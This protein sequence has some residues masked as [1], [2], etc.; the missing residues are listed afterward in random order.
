MNCKYE[1]TQ[2][3]FSSDIET[4]LKSYLLINGI[5]SLCIYS[6]VLFESIFISRS[7]EKK[8]QSK[9][10]LY[11][12]FSEIILSINYIIEGYTNNA[13]NCPNHICIFKISI[14]IYFTLCS[15]LW[16]I[17]MA[18][19]LKYTVE[20]LFQ[21]IGSKTTLKFQ[22]NIYKYEL[23]YHF[24]CWIIPL[25]IMI[26]SILT[27]SFGIDGTFCYL[28]KSLQSEKSLLLIFLPLFIPIIV[29]IYIFRYLY[30]TSKLITSTGDYSL[31]KFTR[32]DIILYNHVPVVV[33]IYIRM[34]LYVS[35]YVLFY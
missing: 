28:S 34:Y 18:H 3:R 30:Y 5:F 20:N 31:H 7:I 24:I 10:I 2:I 14:S 11:Y 33:C 16:M 1:N 29:G 15:T 9:K 23:L 27:K 12:T 25:I 6:Y 21:S 32:Y 26:G 13:S 17:C 4:L 8:E 35:M 22:S 19:S